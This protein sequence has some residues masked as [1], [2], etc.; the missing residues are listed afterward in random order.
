MTTSLRLLLEDYLSLMRE[1][2][3][4][5]V[6]LPL[7]MAAM[8]HEVTYRP[9][10]GPRQYGV[11]VASIG[12]DADGKTKLFLWLIKC[13]DIGRYDWN[14]GPQAIRQSID[15]VGDVYI[16]SHL[17]PEH[18]QLDKKLLI[19]TNG[20]FLANINQTIAS[21]LT[22]WCDRNK[23]EAE[24][25]NGSRL[26]SW[27]E[28]YLLNEY[29]LPSKERGLLR[30]MLANVQSPELC[31]KVGRQLID[32]L[33]SVTIPPGIS[34]KAIAK[35]HSMSLRGLATALNVLRVWGQN[36]GNL[37]GPY[38]VA[39]YAVL[40]AWSRYHGELSSSSSGKRIGSELGGILAQLAGISGAYHAK[41]NTH[42]QIQDAFAY[43]FHDSALVSQAVFE[44]IGRLGAVGYF[45]A[46]SAIV[47]GSAYSPAM[48][49]DYADKLEALLASHSCSELPVF[50]HHSAHIH[51]ALV[52]LL[53][54]N[55]KDIA[56]TWMH[57][58]CQRMAYAFENKRYFP[59]RAPF[60]EILQIR[61][62]YL[63]FDDEQLSAST[64]TPILL[65]WC[66]ALE[67]PDAYS[68]LREKV[69]Q[70]RAKTT[71]NFWSSDSGYDGIVN[72]VYALH[73]HG[74][75]EAISE[76]PSGAIEFLEK[77]AAP[78]PGCE[79]IA[80]SAW[81]KQGLTIIPLMVAIHWHLQMPREAIVQHAAALCGIQI[82]ASPS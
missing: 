77:M 45:W 31:I 65:I 61:N 60:D 82:P 40:A 11:D 44:E 28:Q 42:Y 18:K 46:H 79:A 8:G 17:A 13:D 59:T 62:S 63:E 22:T 38:R 20:E 23:V 74:V 58:M 33:L 12:V 30:R 5:D 29:V 3:E 47:T 15:D 66:A 34:K 54:V 68:F 49:M 80:N 72:D 53:A 24:Q 7:L 70:T 81:Y 50:D 48:A 36:E 64:L 73:A 75:G 32:Q 57:K 19:V 51:A 56:R 26:A 1:E 9:Q 55:R 39:E 4:L 41:L 2:G 67:M 52:L 69:L 37:L 27:T 43:S 78:L 71:P 76:I 35:A 16:R 25:V 6:F 10:K 21:Y 14:S